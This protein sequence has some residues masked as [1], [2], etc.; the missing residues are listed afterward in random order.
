VYTAAIVTAA[1]NARSPGR[2][3]PAIPLLPLL[4]LLVVL[5]V[6][7]LLVVALLV[8]LVVELIFVPM[9]AQVPYRYV[10]GV[11]SAVGVAGLSYIGGCIKTQSD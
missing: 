9:P 10:S 8:V 5:L 1:N 11:V 4:V 6:V 3:T 2:L 7:V